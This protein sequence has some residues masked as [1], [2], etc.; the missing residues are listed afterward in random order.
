MRRCYGAGGGLLA[1]NSGVSLWSRS[2][3][4]AVGKAAARRLLGTSAGRGSQ[5]MVYAA[6][7]ND[8]LFNLATEE[9]IFREGDLSKQ[10]LYLWRNSPTVVIG[11]HQNPFK[12]CHLQNMEK[13]GVVLARRHSGGGAVYQDLGNSCFTF[14]SPRAHFDKARNTN[15]IINALAE[16][17]GIKATA[18]GRNDILVE[19]Q[20]ISGSAYKVSGERALHHGTLLL[21]VDLE[22]LA[23]YLNPDKAK[24]MSKGVSSVKARVRNLSTLN[25]NISH[26]TISQ[27]LIK[28]FFTTYN[29][30]CEVEYLDFD[31]LRTIPSLNAYYEQLKDWNWRFGETPNFEH[32]MEHRFDW[33]NM[34]IHIDS[35]GG[36]ISK[37]KVFSDSL[38]PQMI[39]IFERALPGKRY[40]KEGV[41]EAI[42][43]TK[44]VCAEGD[45]LEA[46]LQEL[47]RWLVDTI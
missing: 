33:G 29:A 28:Q 9:W 40:S 36:V 7:T 43:Q 14:L 11:K 22:A 10:T 17:F 8:P 4:N 44:A 25:P 24:L 3:G 46:H 37:A 1:A 26:E 20:K 2:S 31:K 38:Y 39:T 42:Q 6:Q 45:A 13:E 19:G 5:V 35:S 18:S 12:E 34:D 47:E 23:Q 41:A 21:N 15:I 30:E 16:S 32:H 27:A